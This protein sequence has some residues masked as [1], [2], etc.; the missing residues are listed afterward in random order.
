VTSARIEQRGACRGEKGG[1]T[2][3]ATFLRIARFPWAKASSTARVR[4][5]VKG[6]L[7]AG[8]PASRR[9]TKRWYSQLLT[10]TKNIM[11][12]LVIH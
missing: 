1:N 5:A 2:I 10:S 7:D 12:L 11:S 4:E 9:C 6:S 3:M 8:L